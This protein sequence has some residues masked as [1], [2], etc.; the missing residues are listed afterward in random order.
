[1]IE[2]ADD[3]ELALLA[4]GG[5]GHAFDVLVRRHE[6]R[7]LMVSRSVLRSDADAQD[8]VQNALLKAFRALQDGQLRGSPRPWLARIAQNE[9]RSLARVRREFAPLD[10]EALGAAGDPFEA[11]VM[12]ER[13]TTLVADVAA[14]PERLREPLLLRADGG[15]S[16]AEI[17]GRIGMSAATARQAVFDARATLQAGAAARED[18]CAEIRTILTGRDLRRLRS[19]RVR[20]HLRTCDSCRAFRPARQRLLFAP[21]V[22][23]A[24]QWLGATGGGAATAVRSTAIV[25]AVASGSLAVAGESPHAVRVSGA[26]TGGGD[27]GKTAS[28][29]SGAG[30]A[31]PGGAGGERA[32]GAGGAG[33]ASGAGG[34]RAGGAGGANLAGGAGGAIG[35]TRSA[36]ATLASGG[37]AIG[38]D[39]TRGPTG[40][41][42]SADASRVGTASRDGTSS[43]SRGT[44]PPAAATPPRDTASAA[45]TTSP[46]DTAPGAATTSPRG[47]SAASAT[48]GSSHPTT[49]ASPAASP[50]APAAAPAASSGASVSREVA[51]EG[52]GAVRLGA[53]PPQSG[54]A[55]RPA[56]QPG[57]G[58][59]TQPATGVD[60]APVA[61]GT[62][63]PSDDTAEGAG[64][65]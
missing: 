62:T 44:A 1:V 54:A 57:N 2:L 64:D 26:A 50:A 45:A 49:T 27:G 19:R 33:G 61:G 25:A 58:A 47:A 56:A 7:L 34:E 24:W 41:D 10:P 21:F 28:A 15:L 31:T 20:G 48:C 35:V 6:A 3:D 16:Y 65:G 60:H 42:G 12:K 39:H 23:S 52:D 40:A 11:I 37:S 43:A 63:T 5:S 14:L 29:R 36:G 13:L 53:S 9:A 59:G 8:A 55:A 17:G 46:R 4:A 38:L 51:A 18:D 22:W 30:A 32:G